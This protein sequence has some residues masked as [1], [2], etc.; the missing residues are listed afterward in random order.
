MTNR[1]NILVR[2]MAFVLAM[3][4]LFTTIGG[5]VIYASATAV[6]DAF[7]SSDVL[8]DLM[9]ATI[10]DKPFNILDYPYH[11]EGSLQVISFTEYFFEE[12]MTA[13]LS[14]ELDGENIADTYEIFS[15]ITL[16]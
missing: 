15:Q 7:K 1:K 9:G 2:I 6:E 3:R 11:S 12:E 16:R 14:G 8:E 10:G 13:L 5:G 4:L